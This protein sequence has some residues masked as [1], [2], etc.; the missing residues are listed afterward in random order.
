[1]DEES[2]PRC[3]PSTSSSPQ[4]YST[5]SRDPGV[6]INEALRVAAL[7]VFISAWNF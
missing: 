6:V 5:T 1:M 2:L 3:G 7:G 4:V